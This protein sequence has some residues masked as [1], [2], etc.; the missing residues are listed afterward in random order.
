MA[1]LQGG[2]SIYERVYAL[3]FVRFRDFDIMAR[4]KLS[5]FLL[6]LFL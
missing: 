2:H 4:G 3:N 5:N 1:A 6:Q